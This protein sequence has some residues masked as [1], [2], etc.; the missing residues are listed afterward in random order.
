MKTRQIEG[1]QWQSTT[2]VY[3]GNSEFLHGM[4]KDTASGPTLILD[5]TS[6]LKLLKENN[7]AIAH[8]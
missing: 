7:N 1:T 5:G 3:Q 4:I 6:A 8:S 2:G